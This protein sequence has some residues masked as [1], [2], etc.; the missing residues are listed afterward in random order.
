MLFLRSLHCFINCLLRQCSVLGCSC[1]LPIQDFQSFLRHCSVLGLDCSIFYLLRH[2]SI[3]EGLLPLFHYLFD[4][5]LHCS[6]F[7][8]SP[9]LFVASLYIFK[10][11]LFH[12][13]FVASLLCSRL[14]LLHLLFVMSLCYFFKVFIISLPVCYVI[15]LSSASASS[16]CYATLLFLEGFHCLIIC[17]LRHFSVLGFNC[18]IFCLLHHYTISSRF[19]LFHYLFITSL[20][21]SRLRLF[22][23]L[24]VMSLS[25]FFKL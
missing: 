9:L 21:C 8:L 16:F 18:S 19:P 20:L 11:P 15:T 7:Q 6:R 2:Y 1:L 14:Q 22:H 4:M 5:S 10:F 25:Y 13:L 23:L 3:S 24:L 17:L 12:Y